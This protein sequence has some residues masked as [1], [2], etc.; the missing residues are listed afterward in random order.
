MA[1]SKYIY[2][3]IAVPPSHSLNWTFLLM[4]YWNVSQISLQI[5]PWPQFLYWAALAKVYRVGSLCRMSWQPS[6]FNRAL[7]YTSVFLPQFCYIPHASVYNAVSTLEHHLYSQYVV[8]GSIL[9][10]HQNTFA[11]T[12]LS[13]IRLVQY[14]SGN[15]K[16][17][18]TVACQCTYSTVHVM[19]TLLN[20]ISVKW[21]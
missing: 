3:D 9:E 10:E 17:A 15:W 12:S 6:L 2:N 20:Y 4:F 5:C 8:R 11:S 14:S 7:S 21:Q 1:V 16:G 19:E 18:G 13:S